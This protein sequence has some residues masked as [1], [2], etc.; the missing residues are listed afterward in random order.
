MSKI[1]V[2]DD[3]ESFVRV[4]DELALLPRV[5]LDTEVN[6]MFAYRPRVCL[7]QLCAYSESAPAEEVFVIDTLA[8][9]T[10]APLQS[11]LGS[12]YTTPIIHDVAYDARMLFSEG[13]RLERA[14]DTALHARFLGLASTGLGHFL[15][16]KFGVITDKEL[17]RAD[18]GLRPLTEQQL[19]YVVLDV[20]YLSAIA[21]DLEAAALTAEIN[22]EIGEETAW[23]LRSA[24]QLPDPEGPPPY[25]SLK[26]IREMLP[27]SRAILREMWDLR[28][29]F[30]RV[31][32]VPPGRILG[33]QLLVHLARSRPRDL[34]SFRGLAA[35]QGRD[36]SDEMVE[37]F[38]QCMTAGE[39]AG[40]VPE[41]ERAHF[42]ISKSPNGEIASRRIREERLSQWR[43]EQATLRTVSPQVI[44]PGH[45]LTEIAKKD[46]KTLDALAVVDGFGEVRV[47][48]YGNE[49]L[50]LLAGELSVVVTDAPAS[51]ELP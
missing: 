51:V 18:W 1:V 48:R 3:L 16:E 10:I 17:Q 37:Q 41:N 34:L 50:A 21:T 36:L 29:Q 45:V 40:D 19:E 26:G 32:D 22:E 46:P 5:C 28:D 6:A 27:E 31:K 15:K 2:I 4:V 38:I 11:L 14:V 42:V 8:T 9:K 33:G 24:M 35:A 44:L 43:L 23:A 25:G 30:A 47:R 20:A 12:A 39:Q 7:V 49:L 13:L